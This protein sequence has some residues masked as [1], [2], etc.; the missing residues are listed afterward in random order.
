MRQ[1]QPDLLAEFGPE[2]M[3]QAALAAEAAR[4]ALLAAGGADRLIHRIDD[5]GDGD[6]PAGRASR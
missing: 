6:A 1:E 5:R 2:V 3:R 4:R